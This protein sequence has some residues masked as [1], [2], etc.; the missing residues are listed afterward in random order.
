M[1]APLLRRSLWALALAAGLVVLAVLALP[2][3]GLDAPGA[4]PHRARDERVERARRLDRRGARNQRVARPA[5]EPD[6]RHA[7]PARRGKT[8]AITAERVEIELSAL[9]A[10]GGNV[11]FSRARFIRPT[12]RI[13]GGRG[14]PCP[15][16]RRQ[17]RP[18]HRDGARDRGRE[19]HRARH[20][21]A[22][23]RTSSASW[24]S[25]TA[26]IVAVSGGAETEIVTGLVRKDRLGRT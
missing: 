7:V 5:G 23:R 14:G 19:P 21:T 16:A 8:P 13:E 3:A 17:D 22:A 15:A 18:G 26:R 9:A 2:Y 25:P 1:P 10:L 12:I 6:R 11:D 4:R 20:R 24:N